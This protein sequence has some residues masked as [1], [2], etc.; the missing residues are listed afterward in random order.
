MNVKNK[1]KI[2]DLKLDEKTQ[3]FF[4]QHRIE[5]NRL[6]S[7]K[8]A[9]AFFR[10]MGFIVDKEANIKR[11]K[12]SSLKYLLKSATL[13]QLYKISKAEKVQATWRLRLAN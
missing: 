1:F 7:F 13:R 11:S 3:E 2:L 12:L 4:E 9:E 10:R 8:E 5:D 6:E